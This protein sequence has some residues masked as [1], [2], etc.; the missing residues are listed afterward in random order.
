LE[1]NE[2]EREEVLGELP[3]ACVVIAKAN[4]MLET[5]MNTISNENIFFFIS[6][7][8]FQIIRVITLLYNRIMKGL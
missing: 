5:R 3:F 2:P 6:S 4:D 8:S 7:F 1:E